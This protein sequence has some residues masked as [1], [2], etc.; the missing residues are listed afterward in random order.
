[1]VGQDPERSRMPLESVE[2]VQPPK[3]QG[4][5]RLKMVA[6]SPVHSAPWVVSRTE[7]SYRTKSVSAVV[8]PL[9]FRPRF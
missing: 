7:H 2:E 9:L 8:W 5:K 1:M 3:E 4:R 6:P